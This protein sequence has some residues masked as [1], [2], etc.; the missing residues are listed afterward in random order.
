MFNDEKLAG[1]STQFSLPTVSRQ[2]AILF[3][4]MDA[5]DKVQL[6]ENAR[7]TQNA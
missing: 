6:R 1:N 2:N 4:L 3:R 7:T 5:D